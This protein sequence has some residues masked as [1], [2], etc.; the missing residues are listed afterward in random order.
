MASVDR[1]KPQKKG[2]KHRIR[3]EREALQSL[4][5]QK[6]GDPMGNVRSQIRTAAKVA[7]IATVVVWLIALSMWSGLDS[8]IPV[9]VALVLTIAL[10][11]AAFFVWRNLNKS[12]ELG[13]LVSE[14]GGLSDEERADRI[15]KLDELV[16]KGD[17]AA[18]IAKAQLEMQTD[19]KAAL[20]T[21]EK[22]NLEKA[23]KL[24]AAQVRTMRGMIHL[25]SSEVNAA[26][27]LVDPIDLAAVPDMKIRANF[28]GIIAEAWA[29]SGNPIEAK[30][31]LDKYD[32]DDKDFE[33]ARVQLLRARA[34]ASVHTNDLNTMKRA[35]KALEEIS[36]QLMAQ[37]LSQKRVHPLLQQEARKRIEK[38]GLVPR[39]RIMARR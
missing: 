36:P 1:E 3:E 31:L 6:R 38:S 11:V 29:R 5:Q 13:A 10:G 35:L 34:F 15:A 28:A 8:L 22:V 14:A 27:E 20:A 24:V 37:F 26:R 4:A 17:A 23:Q 30:Q 21:L 25:M 19:P 2:A 7:G 39:Q 12:T 33:D 16:A 18:I 32:A 9:W